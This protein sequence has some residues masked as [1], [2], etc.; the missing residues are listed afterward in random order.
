MHLLIILLQQLLGMLPSKKVP[1]PE[2]VRSGNP[3]SGSTS[4]GPEPDAFA[5]LRPLTSWMTPC[6]NVFRFAL[7]A[8]PWPCADRWYSRADGWHL[9]LTLVRVAA[10]RPLRPFGAAVARLRAR[11]ARPIELRPVTWADTG[12]RDV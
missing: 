5:L 10:H 12:G 3:A 2:V 11:A 7:S 8:R 9:A 6:L 1:Q 4:A